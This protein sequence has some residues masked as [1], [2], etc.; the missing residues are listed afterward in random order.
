VSIDNAFAL[1]EGHPKQKSEDPGFTNQNLGYPN[2]RKKSED[3]GLKI[4]TLIG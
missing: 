2:P 1:I 4:K 3:P